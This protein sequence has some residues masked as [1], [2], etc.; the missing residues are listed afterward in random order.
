[1]LYKAV[2]IS[3]LAV[4]AA[5]DFSQQA[6]ATPDVANSTPKA[7][8]SNYVVPVGTP[9]TPQ[10]EAGIATPETTKAREF[11]Q[12]AQTPSRPTNNNNVVVPVTPVQPTN[13]VTGNTCCS[14]YNSITDTCKAEDYQRFSRHSNGCQGKRCNSGTTAACFEYN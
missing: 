5:A 1:M 14:T 2:A 9:S 8:A 3:T 10:K 13:P 6:L 4:L 12:V 7:T 11:A